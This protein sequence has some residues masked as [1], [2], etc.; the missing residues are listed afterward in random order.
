MKKLLCAVLMLCM[1]A[2]VGLAEEAPALSW[3]KVAPVLEQ[4]NVKGQFVAFDEIAI[5]IWLLDGLNAV[6][7]SE[8]D[9]ANG[10][11]GYFMPADESARV[12]VMYVNVN[13]MGLED[14]A[15]YLS[16]ESDVADVQI[17]TVNGLA[18]V[19]YK[20]P[21]K[22]SMSMAFSTEAGYLL[23]VTCA[24]ASQE[25]ADLVWGAVFASIQAE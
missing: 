25:N 1:L 8:E 13:G 22:D 4:G 10:L 3:E 18:C 24:P 7:L 9:R 20:Q 17:G 11:I 21:E 6:K 19:T 2:T 23:E 16:G 12:A 15:N 14:Y 5:K